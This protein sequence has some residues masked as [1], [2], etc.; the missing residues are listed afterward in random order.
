MPHTKEHSISNK[1]PATELTSTFKPI[2]KNY[3]F[4][5]F[6]VQRMAANT[7]KLIQLID[8]LPNPTCSSTTECTSNSDI[9]VLTAARL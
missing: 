5:K 3:H 2:P 1:S 4:L 9:R 6:S 7:E 8:Q